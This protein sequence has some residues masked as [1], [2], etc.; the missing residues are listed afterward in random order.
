M[1]SDP[2]GAPH[3]LYRSRLD[4]KLAG[5]CGGIGDYFRIDPVMVRLLW[6]AGTL[7]SAGFGIILYIVAIL[8]VPNDPREASPPAS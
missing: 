6:V 5:V 1:W 2:V 3:R 4:R 8:V 7:V